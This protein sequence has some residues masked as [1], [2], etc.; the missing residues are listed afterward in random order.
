M[1]IFSYMHKYICVCNRRKIKLNV[2]EVLKRVFIQAVL[3][4][5]VVR[6]IKQSSY[7]ESEIS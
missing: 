1:L 4:E 2:G 3:L 7:V 6:V 5:A